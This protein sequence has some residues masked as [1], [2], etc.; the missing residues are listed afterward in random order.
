MIQRISCPGSKGVRAVNTVLIAIASVALLGLGQ[1]AKAQQ[2]AETYVLSSA[3]RGETVFRVIADQIGIVPGDDWTFEAVLEEVARA[4]TEVI[5]ADEDAQII[6]ARTSTSARTY[7][8]LLEQA[9]KLMAATGSAVRWAGPVV[10]TGEVGATADVR[11]LL[12]PTNVVIVKVLKGVDADQVLAFAERSGLR[13]LQRNPVDKL[14]YYFEQPTDQT[15][16]NVF[17]VSQALLETRMVEY[18]VP[19]FLMYVDIRQSTLNDDLFDWQ[20]PLRNTGQ[21]MGLEGADIDADSA[22]E[23]GL[24]R[25]GVIIAVI[26]GGFDMAHPDLIPNIFVNPG[27]NAGNNID[28]DG[29]GYV[30]DRNGWDF[31]RDC[32]GVPVPLG[33]GD[34]DPTGSDNREGRHGTMTSGAAAAAGNNGL[35]VTGSCPNCSVLPLRVRLSQGA[36]TELSLAFAYAQAAGA[37]II[38]N[39]WGIRLNGA[40]T[41]P[42]ENA[43]NNATM[44]GAAVFF[45]M[46]STG[47]GGYRNDCVT[48]DISSLHNV[49]A[50][51]ASNNVDTRTPAGYGDCMALLAPTDNEGA[52]AGTLW[53]VSTDMTGTA[54]YNDKHQIPACASA[55]LAPPPPDRLSYTLC[56]NGTSYAA[57]LTAGV[58]GLMESLDS[59]LT[60]ERHRQVLQDTADKIQPSIAAYDPQTGFSSPGAVPTPL[61]IGSPAVAGSTH[62]FGRVN[63]FEAVRLVA[64]AANGGRG[65]VDLFLRDNQLDWG[66]TAEPS[67]V[68]LDNPRGFIPDHQSASIKID[69]PPY[70]SAPPTTPQEFADFPDEEPRAEATNKIYV[71]VRNRGRNDATNVTV[72]LAA[73]KPLDPLPPD[74]WGG[75][76]PDGSAITTSWALVGTRMIPSVGYSGASIALKPGDEAQIAAFEFDAP[77]LDPSL[78]GSRDYSMLAVVDCADDHVSDGSRA[79]FAPDLIAPTDNNVTLR[80]VSLQDPLS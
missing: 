18:A 14:E 9:S 45:A 46:S 17:T 71:L 3:E 65:E 60:P 29:N 22:W 1:T 59:T 30:D 38:S 36:A 56:A 41:W 57:P 63:A 66:N 51:S 39:S 34:P 24:G 55:D 64:P 33:C 4:G 12:I 25:H 70:E 31:T 2:I 69:A 79:N 40:V 26:D 6:I 77:A 35:G 75:E 61:Q 42:V 19:N 13:L 62:G 50:V 80:N 23:F 5:R 16:F 7:T 49:I 10:V 48:N 47:E 76:V 73:G 68:L 43:I 11:D 67:D 15:E 78:P 28:D 52:N 44:A 21:N 72:Q 27:E 32:W 54:G 20:W 74:F 58:A 37:D 53:P 8:A